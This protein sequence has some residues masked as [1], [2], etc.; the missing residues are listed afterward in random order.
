MPSSYTN[1]L[2]VEKPEDGEQD[3][4]WGDVVNTNMDIIDRAINGTVS[5]TLSGTSSTLTTSDGVL[6][7]GQYKLLA[8]GG[9]PSGTHTITI[10]PNDAAKIY[11]VS[12]TSGQSVVFAQGSGSTATVANGDTAIIYAF[13]TGSTSGVANLTDHFGM[14]SPNITGGAINGTPIGGTT[15]AAGAFT[16]GTF[17]LGAVTTP[18]ITIT[19]DPNTGL[20][21]PGA[22]T[23][24]ISTAGVERARVHSNGGVSINNTVDPGA[25]NLSVTGN[26]YLPAL[27]TETRSLEVGN[28][29]AGN[30][31]SLIDLVGD[32]TYTDYGARFLRGD[33]GQNAET[34]LYH[35]GTG[36]FRLYAQE[37]APIVLTTDNAERVR[38]HA[39]GGFSIGNTTDPGAT[40]LSVTG[41]TRTNGL[42]VTGGTQNWTVTASGTNLTFAYNGVNVM[43]ISST[44][45]LTVIGN[46]TA[47]GTIT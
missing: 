41:T 21:S 11:F 13:G 19:G 3:G 36:P 31:A 37:A 47:F 26:L 22:D 40:N 16:T 25:N 9:T 33:T 32:A 24:A 29:R 7:N 20:W 10:T 45:D 42:T 2:G 34:A 38:L 43:R 28:Q 15:A 6:S 27:T 18:S 1:N 44:G 5:I 23:I 35:R 46:V 14:S 8:L 17:G 12:N 30:G 39:S 4:V